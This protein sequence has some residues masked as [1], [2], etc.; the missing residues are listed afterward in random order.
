MRN[1]VADLN[2]R[3]LLV[4]AD[5]DLQA[6]QDLDL[7][8]TLLLQ[9]AGGQLTID[10]GQIP[11]AA[12]TARVVGALALSQAGLSMLQGMADTWQLKTGGEPPR[13]VNL[14]AS[15]APQDQLS[16]ALRAVAQLYRAQMSPFVAH[17][18]SLLRQVAGL[19]IAQ[20]HTLSQLS[21]TETFLL[22]SIQTRRWLAQ[23][24][25][26]VQTDKPAVIAL[27]PDAQLC[28]RLS[29]SSMGVSDVSFMLATQDVPIE[30]QLTVA[31]YLVETDET[32]AQWD[33]PAADLAVGWQR[34]SLIRALGHDEQT[35]QLRL[36]WKGPTD[37]LLTTA[38]RHPDP[39]YCAM[40]GQD[41]HDRVLAHQ[42]WKYLPN[43]AAPLPT[44]THW[45]GGPVPA[46]FYIDPLRL[47]DAISVNLDKEGLQYFKNLQALQ[48]HP[49]VGV[50]SAARLGRAVP[51]SVRQISATVAARSEHSPRIEYALATAPLHPVRTIG[52]LVM[53]CERHGRISD[54]VTLSKDIQGQVNLH[55][56]A[57]N[58]HVS[59]LYLLTRLAPGAGQ[60]RAWA[61]FSNIWLSA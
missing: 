3:L 2:N 25:G 49:F 58:P 37:L 8:A 59:D 54:W 5:C 33:L 36:H 45:I 48:V 31:L 6:V 60:Q 50:V 29:A 30:G 27:S 13:I 44:N 16:A 11:I 14:S 43:T 23:S 9:H 24:H 34:V 10:G 7:P 52:D 15:V 26:P 18:S 42:V 22:K 1:T 40:T 56:R 35:V 46:Q 53:D 32:V 55:L 28:Q 4:V 20:E 38:F 39:A 61:T 21:A 57:P 51:R 12:I 47:A 41:T 17:N 19:R